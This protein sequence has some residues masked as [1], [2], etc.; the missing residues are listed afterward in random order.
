MVATGATIAA[1]AFEIYMSKF[2]TFDAI[3]ANPVEFAIEFVIVLFGVLKQ[4]GIWKQLKEQDWENVVID[5]KHILNKSSASV[6]TSGTS[7]RNSFN[8]R[9]SERRTYY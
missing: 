8:V 2:K 5:L 3:K 1:Q 7:I 9:S 4:P 6:N